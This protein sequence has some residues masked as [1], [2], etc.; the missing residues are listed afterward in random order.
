M[1]PLCVSDFCGD[2]L[3]SAAA[4][5]APSRAVQQRRHSALSLHPKPPPEVFAGQW[6]RTEPSPGIQP[7]GS[8]SGSRWEQCWTS[9]WGCG[10][11]PELD[12]WLLGQEQVFCALADVL[13][14]PL[15]LTAGL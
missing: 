6:L 13:S 9:C 8:C 5:A 11:S 7:H 15:T 12:V 4:T 10:T 1:Q 3:H 2:V 14:K